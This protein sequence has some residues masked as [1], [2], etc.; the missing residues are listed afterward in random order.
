MQ[1]PW[2]AKIVPAN[3]LRMQNCRSQNAEY[4]IYEAKHGYD[5]HTVQ[6]GCAKPEFFLDIESEKQKAHSGKIHIS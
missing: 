6:D 2:Q 3:T 1:A 4:G 5:G